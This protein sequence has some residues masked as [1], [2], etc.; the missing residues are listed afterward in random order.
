[1]TSKELITI[2][3]IRN[4]IPI[5]QVEKIFREVFATISRELERGE[6][7]QIVGF[8]TF[9]VKERL[10][11]RGRNPRTGEPIDLPPTKHVHFKQ[12]RKIKELLNDDN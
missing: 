5:K 11:R 7:V 12:G 9:S 1:M 2:A 8:G 4:D 3:A 6:R 10:P